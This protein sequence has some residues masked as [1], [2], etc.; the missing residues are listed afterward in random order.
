MLDVSQ[1]AYIIFFR[2]KKMKE[3]NQLSHFVKKKVQKVKCLSQR[4]SWF[5]ASLCYCWSI[6][7]LTL[8]GKH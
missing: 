4:V 2:W 8:I 3:H 7:G 6:A 5:I 1:P